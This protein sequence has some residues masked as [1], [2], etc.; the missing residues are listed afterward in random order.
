[1]ARFDLVDLYL[2]ARRAGAKRGDAAGDTAKRFTDD[3]NTGVPHQEIFAIVGKTAVK[4]MDKWVLALKRSSYDFT[5]LAPHHGEHRK[6]RR[7][8]SDDEL[9]AMLRFALHHNQL[10]LSSVIRMACLDLKNRGIPPASSDATLRRA[11]EDWRDANYDKW[12]LARRGEKALNDDVLPYIERNADILAVGDCLVADGH[13]LNF[14]V[15]NP[16]TGKACRATLVLFYDWASRYPAGWEIMVTE[17]VQ[18]VHAALRR[19]ILTLGKIPRAVYLDN[20]KAFKAKVFNKKGKDVDFGQAGFQGLYRRL[21]IETHFAIPYNAQSKPVERFFGTFNEL[22]RLLPSYIGQSIDDKPA[23]MHRNEKLHQKLHNPIVPTIDQANLVIRSWVE[24]AYACRP[25]RGL[26][27][28]CPADVWEQGRGEGVDEEALRYLMMTVSIETVHRNGITL[29]GRNYYHERLYGYRLPV[30]VRYDMQDMS[31]VWIFTADDREFLCEATPVRSINPMVSLN[32]DKEDLEALKQASRQ[33]GGLKRQTIQATIREIRAAAVT[34]AP[35]ALPE[36][37]RPVPEALPLSPAAVE[38]IE[39][40]A[41]QVQVIHLEDR[42][43]PDLA[44]WDGDV[45]ERLLKRRAS[46]ATL[47]DDEAVFMS[48]F[49]KTANYRML[50][51]Y[52]RQMEEDLLAGGTAEANG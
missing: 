12:T 2:K 15:I 7:A 34:I 24:D 14:Q 11:L 28:A 13:T 4:T 22:E 23:W 48:T 43:D 32:G 44:V 21:G 42:K 8:V 16:F 45:Y 3:Y 25:H 51:D 5:A 50:A 46:G 39:R 27:G 40:E 33:K 35:W 29:F 52:Y 36:T 6:G 30:L 19:A 1:M 41:A 18:C 37:A 10:S 20:G 49:E 47:G 38:D 9:Q 31:K 17:N 26:N